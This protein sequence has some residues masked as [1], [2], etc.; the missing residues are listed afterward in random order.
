MNIIIP[1]AGPDFDLP[2]REIRPLM[3]FENETLFEKCFIRRWES[4]FKTYNS[5]MI[6]VFLKGTRYP[7]FEDYIQ[8]TWPEIK[9]SSVVLSELSKGALFSALAGV[10]LITNPNIP[11]VIDLADI[12]FDWIEDP[13]SVFIDAKVHGALPIFSAQDPE[14]SYAKVVEG[15]VLE[16]VE[17]KVVSEYASAGVYLY[18]DLSAFYLAAAETIMDR[19]LYFNEA[20]FLCPSLNGLIRKDLLVKAL[21]VKNVQPLSLFFKTLCGSHACS[22]KCQN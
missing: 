2:G 7:V 8:A 16:T 1:M 20:A 10:S 13:M 18:R 15:R 21:T 14:F 4:Y 5:Q 11:V 12:G 6:F 22:V 3:R 9:Y 17:K 19:S